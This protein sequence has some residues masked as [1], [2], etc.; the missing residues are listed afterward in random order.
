MAPMDMIA[1]SETSHA[2]RFSETSITRSPG[3]TPWASS[4]RANGVTRAA[5]SPQLNAL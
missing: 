2:G 5:V 3:S 1:R 4:P